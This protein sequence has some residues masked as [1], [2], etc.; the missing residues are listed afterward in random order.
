MFQRDHFMRQ[1]QQLTQALAQILVKKR[2]EEYDEALADIQAAGQ[3]FLGID[4]GAA[5]TITYEEFIKRLYEAD[6]LDAERG[7]IA[8][9]LLRQQGE[10]FGLHGDD[11]RAVSSNH[12][13]LQLY[14]QVYHQGGH[15]QSPDTAGRIEALVA[16]VD[17][18]DAL[19]DTQKLLFRYYD[20]QGYFDKAEDVLF[21]L[22]EDL[23]EGGFYEAG[24]AFFQRLWQKTPRELEAGGLP[25]HEVGQG[26]R[27]F[28]RKLGRLA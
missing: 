17:W 4:L 19:Q 14:L 3:L 15:H 12:L 7:A 26:L 25:F 23:P 13:A 11:E 18:H 28:K 1:I 24:V 8:A 16:E 6:L 10:L 27:A 5:Q 22:A 21:V 20:H 2:N 9:E